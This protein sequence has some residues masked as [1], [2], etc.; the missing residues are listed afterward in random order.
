VQPDRQAHRRR[1]ARALV[2]TAHGAYDC[3]LLIDEFYS[4]L[5]LPNDAAFD[6]SPMVSAARYVEERRLAIRRDSST[7]HQELALPGLAND[8]GH[9]PQERHRELRQRRVLSRR[10]RGRSRCSAR[11]I[12]LLEESHVRAETLAIQSAFRAK[13]DRMISRLEHIG[14]RFDRLPEGTF[15]AWGDVSALPPPLSDGMSLFRSALERRSSASRVS[16]ST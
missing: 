14:V 5:R 13:R 11:A 1:R 16:S 15:Y 4:A 10:R 2:A 3:S 6:G 7:A 8:V 12:P 9:R